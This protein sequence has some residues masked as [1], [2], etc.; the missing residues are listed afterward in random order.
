MPGAIDGEWVIVWEDWSRG[1]RGLHDDVIGAYH[2]MRNVDPT[3]P[4]QLTTMLG[5]HTT[6]TTANDYEADP[7]AALEYGGVLYTPGGRYIDNWP[8]DAVAADLDLGSGIAVTDLIE[9]DNNLVAALSGANIRV[10]SGGSWG[11]AGTNAA[12]HLALVEDRLWRATNTNEVSNIQAGTAADTG[13]WSSGIPIGDDDILITDLN[14]YGERLAVSKEDG[15]YLG[16]EGAVF[17]NVLPHV[18]GNRHPD[19]GKNTFVHGDA[20]YYPMWDGTLLR[21]REGLVEDVSIRR[22]ITAWDLANEDVPGDVVMSMAS[23]GSAVWAATRS[24]GSPWDVTGNTSGDMLKTTDNEGT[25]TNYGL[26]VSDGSI[27][28]EATLDA[29]DT[30]GNG[31]YFY[32]GY[33]AVWYGARI[34]LTSPNT[35][36][37]T[38]T[39]QYWNGSAWT[40]LVAAT[41]TPYDGT[42]KAG[43]TLAQSGELSWR[44]APADWATTTINT[45]SAFW[46]R[47][48][49]S[50]ALDAKVRVSEVRILTSA[51]RCTIWRGRP[52]R[53]ADGDRPIVWDTVY[54][55]AGIRRPTGLAFVSPRVYPW[56]DFGGLVVSARNF[57]SFIALEP[58]HLHS[59]PFG[60]SRRTAWRAT[61]THHYGGMPFTT[62]RW[63][64]LT[65]QGP[66]LAAG[67]LDI[68]Y[69]L[70]GANSWTQLANDVS[71]SGTIAAQ[72]ISATGRAIQW[73]LEP[74][75]PPDVG[76]LSDPTAQQ[77]QVLRVEVRF[78]ELPTF[79]AEFTMALELAPGQAGPS[80]GDMVH[81]A[82]QVSALRALQTV[83]PIT[84]IDPTGVSFTVMVRDVQLQEVNQSADEYPTLL[85][86]VRATET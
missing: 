66:A 11:A 41:H 40:T 49:V 58:P 70:D 56:M 50:A 81:P 1:A 48:S 13:T 52:A 63:V 10:R 64:D 28:T 24:R 80:G 45:L 42:A 5:T 72:A 84:L 77:A 67:T 19:N 6:Y 47:F 68:Y 60:A 29:L 38:L 16:D 23:D 54:S 20:I 82:A 86:Q 65:V 79:K 74:G 39:M 78:R 4:G 62:K 53:Q 2:E 33:S 34:T 27:T 25:F 57:V 18:A 85:V 37:A 76:I 55:V 61:S 22:Q 17:P 44:A 46:V 9:F 7:L 59:G 26:N 21:Y 8:S 36:A 71:Y 75:T 14:G 43:A 69:R 12:T 35:N 15:L 83:G 73:Y 51:P 30:A 3:V 32:L 31:D